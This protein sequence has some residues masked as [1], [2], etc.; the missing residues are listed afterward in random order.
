M[1][2][3]DPPS[4]SDDNVNNDDIDP[5]LSLLPL[6]PPHQV[7]ETYVIQIPKDQ[8]YRVPPPEH[9]LM[10]E[11]LQNPNPKERKN[12]FICLMYFC[13]F[14]FS[15]FLIVGF[16]YLIMYFSMKPSEPIFSIIQLIVK[17]PKSFEVSF[18]IKNPNK[19]QTVEYG[20]T[21]EVNLLY[22]DEGFAKGKFSELS[23]TEKESSK[24]SI[25]FA[26]KNQKL[27]SKM[28]KS[29]KET[30]TK[31]SVFLNVEMNVPVKFKYGSLSWTYKMYVDCRVKVNTLGKGSK[32]VSQ[33]CKSNFK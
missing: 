20:E 11:R 32:V 18:D 8:I 1:E 26:R 33:D 2:G 4:A 29:L 21:D 27:P 15:I 5:P 9:A 16:S 14:L 24:V 30:K 13:L 10:L 7:T 25:K 6:P 23:Q 31:V 12:R 3:W 22:E 19:K 17:N 28:E